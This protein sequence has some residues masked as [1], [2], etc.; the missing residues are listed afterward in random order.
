M[1]L[2]QISLTGG[3]PFPVTLPKAPQSVN[4][5]LMTE[6]EIHAKLQ[7]GYDD[8]KAERIQDTATAFAK[9]RESH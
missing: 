2:N 6:D 4:A 3:I 1:Y 9:F 7:E 8:V 5:D